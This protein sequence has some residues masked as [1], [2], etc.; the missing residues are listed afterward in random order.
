MHRSDVIREALNETGRHLQTRH[1][2]ADQRQTSDAEAS[3]GAQPWARIGAASMV[4]CEVRARDTMRRHQV[5][6]MLRGSAAV[7]LSACGR[8]TTRGRPLCTCESQLP[9]VRRRHS[10]R[11]LR[12]SWAAPA[13]PA[14]VGRGLGA[15]AAWRGGGGPAGSSGFAVAPPHAGH[16]HAVVCPDPGA[17]TDR[18][19][20]RQH[21]L[22]V[23]AAAG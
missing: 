18:V 7:G 13:R 3:Y 1:C 5:C 9:G 15:G 20:V 16:R 19:A 10:R 22:G 21:E 12:T 8:R 14:G 11:P 4:N 23:C 6:A 2:D 17:C